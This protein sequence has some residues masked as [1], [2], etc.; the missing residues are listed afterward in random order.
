[1]IDAKLDQLV[2]A[3]GGKALLIAVDYK[4]GKVKW[5][6]ANPR[7]WKMTHSS[8]V[9]MEFGGRRMC[10]YCGSGGVAGVAAETG[11]ILWD[12]TAW[13]IPSATCP[14]PVPIGDGRIFLCGGYE[15]GAMMLRIETSGDKFA[16]KS[17]Y[18]LT[19]AQFSSEQQTPVFYNG[20]LYGVRQ[21]DKRLVCLDLDG[22]DV[23]NSGRDKFGAASCMIADGLIL[24][25]NDTGTLTMLEASPQTGYKPLARSEI[26]EDGI[27]AW[28][29]MALVAG[30]LIVRDM[31]RMACLD[32]AD[33]GSD[34]AKEG[35]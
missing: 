1:L 25:L 30:R 29:P 12:T 15:S 7:G 9:P 32:I 5:E 28:G 31:T 19:P 17:L 24:A 23:W 27:D 16:A 21:K 14:S 13:Q 6:S 10:V 3:P 18:R 26:F 8:I 35:P 4:T 20:Y 2:L 11:E 34:A 22:K 33:H